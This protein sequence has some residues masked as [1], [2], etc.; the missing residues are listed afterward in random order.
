M[1]SE[2]SSRISGFY[3]LSIEERRRKIQRGVELTHDE[4]GTLD[5]GGLLP[6]DADNLIENVL[7]TYRFPFA[8][9]PNFQVN[10]RDRLLA[11]VIEEPS[12]VAAAANAARIVR[13]GGGFSAEADPPCMI[14]Q[15]QV[16]GLVNAL[17]S[18]E[19]VEAARAEILAKADECHPHLVARGG[20]ARALEV[21]CLEG[22][23]HQLVVHVVVDCR[24]AMGA[25][26]VNTVA[27]RLGDRVAELAGGRAGL[28]ILSNLADRRC[29]RVRASIPPAALAIAEVPGDQVRDQ[30]VEASRFAELDPYRAATHNKG[31]MNGVDAVCMAAGNDWRSVESGAH[32]FASRSGQYRPLAT[33]NADEKGDLV[34]EL[35]MPMAVGIVGGAIRVHSLAQVAL[36]IMA[37]ESSSDLGM[38]LACAGL[39]SNLAALRAL[40]TIG[41][42]RGHM[43]LH[44]RSVARAAGARDGQVEVVARLLAQ[45]GEIRSE[46]AEAILR[47]LGLS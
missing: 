45:S 15:I 23:P 27:E 7:G 39:A 17:N 5:W 12:V 11:M 32:A 37:V 14:A 4:L 16:V 22:D 21:R 26:I 3:K 36:K 19:R 18:V 41:I 24:D 40:A 33:W 46:K 29:V 34:G 44:A 10:G 43:S 30:I 2:F 20:G 6:V 13:R 8:L 38:L 42:Q 28:R 1:S 25:N 31:I 35:E 9:C 47:Q